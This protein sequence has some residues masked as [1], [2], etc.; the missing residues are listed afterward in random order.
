MFVVLLKFYRPLVCK[1]RGATVA[2]DSLADES[3]LIQRYLIEI[4]EEECKNRSLTFFKSNRTIN[5]NENM[6]IRCKIH[7]MCL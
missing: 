3:Q 5:I 2:I 4:V 6:N 1:F 7:R